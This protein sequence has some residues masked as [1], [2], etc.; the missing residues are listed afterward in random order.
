[1]PIILGGA[2]TIGGSVAK[3]LQRAQANRELREAQKNMPKFTPQAGFAKTLLNARM[4]GAAQ[5]ERNI[6]QTAANQMANAQRA[7][8]SGNQLLLAGAGSASQTNQ[9]FN[10]Q[11]QQEAADYQRRYQNAMAAQQYDDAQKMAE[12]QR[13]L[14]IEGAIA[15]NRAANAGDVANLG[16][17][18]LNFG[19][20]AGMKPGS[21]F[22]GMFDSK[23]TKANA[24]QSE[25]NVGG[26]NM[27][28]RS[29][30][31]GTSMTAGGQARTSPDQPMF[32]V[33]NS[34]DPRNF[35]GAT[36]FQQMYNNLQAAN[37]LN[38]FNPLLF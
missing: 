34:Y 11:Q 17:A 14:D 12:F 27:F 5:A 38:N 19:L 4:P 21:M 26:L 33:T 9:A 1:M 32:Y 16:M 7:S 37:S 25:V 18:G 29:P 15:Q 35:Q 30:Y 24:P 23:M 3:A 28:G 10:Q 22:K 2:L 36:P 6:F 8:A 31:A 13:N 20:S